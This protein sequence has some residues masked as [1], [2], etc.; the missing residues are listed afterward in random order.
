[1]YLV[2][3]VV[4][5]VLGLYGMYAMRQGQSDRN[6]TRIAILAN[7]LIGLASIAMGAFILM[8]KQSL[9]D[10]LCRNKDYTKEP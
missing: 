7:L 1:M 10:L 8:K 4:W 2:I 3:S 6:Y 9:D 5:A